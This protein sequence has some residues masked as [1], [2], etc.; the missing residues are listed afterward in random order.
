MKPGDKDA[1]WVILL[2]THCHINKH[3]IGMGSKNFKNE[4]CLEKDMIRNIFIQLFI[5]SYY[6]KQEWLPYLWELLLTGHHAEIL[7]RV[8]SFNHRDPGRAFTGPILQV[9]RPSK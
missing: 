1:L 7:A 8:I 4:I 6:L 9:R 5:T 3:L 2:M